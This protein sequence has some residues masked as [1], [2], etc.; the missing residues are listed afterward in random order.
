MKLVYIAAPYSH[1]DN[2]IRRCRVRAA[3]KYAGELI[4]KGYNVFSPLTHSVPIAEMIGIDDGKWIAR[5]LVFM[6][7]IDEL[8][9]LKLPGWVV[10]K[11]VQEEIKYAMKLKKEVVY[12]QSIG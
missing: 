9:I 4:Q 7:I 1:I 2:R 8:H 3:T 11:G 5:D 10:S 6:K 12:V